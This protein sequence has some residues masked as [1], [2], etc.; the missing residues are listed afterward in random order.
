MAPA[1]LRARID[2]GEFGV[3]SRQSL[4]PDLAGLGVPVLDAAARLHDLIGAHG[5]VADEDELVVRTVGTHHLDGT[6]M[7]VEA[8]PVIAPQRL[9]RAVVE[10][11]VLEMLEL[12][13]RG[14][15]QLL[16]ST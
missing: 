15:E 4:E 6:H 10:I 14:R 11:E 12:A 1:G 9:V 3:R 2:P 8:A 16:A 5:A 13:A 7:L